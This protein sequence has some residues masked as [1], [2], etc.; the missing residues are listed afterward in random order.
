MLLATDLLAAPSLCAPSVAERIGG[1][2]A[3]L[4]EARDHMR[5]CASRFEHRAALPE[6]TV[7]YRASLSQSRA[8]HA[9]TGLR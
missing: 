2:L 5:T 1:L 8:P 4:E 7:T 6:L 3:D 9:P